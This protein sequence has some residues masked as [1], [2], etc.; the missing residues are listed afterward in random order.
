[1]H[2]VVA[3]L[4]RAGL[5][6]VDPDLLEGL[7]LLLLFRRLRL[8]RLIWRSD[9]QELRCSILGGALAA[10]A[11]LGWVVNRQRSRADRVNDP[12]SASDEGQPSEGGRAEE[13]AGRESRW[14]FLSSQGM[15]QRQD[16]HGH[17]EHRHE[18]STV[19]GSEGPPRYSRR[20]S[21]VGAGGAGV[22]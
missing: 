17:A 5:Q 2:L 22:R 13:V 7:L 19:W 8:P 16:R 3:N 20:G 4:G 10:L 9:L 15:G 11:L 6:E 21:L 14:R 18:A 12:D 1:L